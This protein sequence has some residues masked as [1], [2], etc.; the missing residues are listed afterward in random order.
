MTYIYKEIREKTFPHIVG[1]T[2]I[3]ILSNGLI[4]NWMWFFQRSDIDARNEWDNYT[5]LPYEKTNQSN[6]Q[7]IFDLSNNPIFYSG[8]NSNNLIYFTPEY[9]LEDIQEIM[10]SMAII[11]DGAYRENDFQ[12]GIYNYIEKYSHTLGNAK[13][14]L[15]CYSFT[16]DT[17]SS[18][19]QPQGVFNTNFFKKTEFELK[20][21]TP[22][23]DENNNVKY[24]CDENGDIISITK[25]N[26]NLYK[27]TYTMTLQEE[28][29]NFLVF[30]NGMVNKKMMS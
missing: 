6:N 18:K 17:N 11:C 7:Y 1:N 15:Y 24:V 21:I 26:Q 9:E 4:S 3:D 29:Y 13:P 28:R 12:S 25:N 8:D 5:N 19:I 20:T 27:Y 16:L 30:Q 10:Q 23:I 14:G 2:K 22:N